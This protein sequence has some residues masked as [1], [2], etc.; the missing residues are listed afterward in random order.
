MPWLERLPK[1]GFKLKVNVVVQRDSNVDE[2]LDFVALTTKMPVHIRF[3]EFMP[4][5]GNRWNRDEV[6]TYQEMLDLIVQRFEIEKLVDKPNATAKS[7]RVPNA[8]GTFAVISTVS[9]PFCGSCNRMRI[10]AEGKMR[11]CLFSKGETDLLSALRKGE[12]IRPL[13]AQ[14]LMSKHASLGGLPD[15][16]EQLVDETELSDRSMIRIGG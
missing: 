1:E 14:N 16:N 8:P 3:I 6:F 13:V 5:D 7:Y 4:F 9:Q 11:N 2:L 10:T 12:D 15:L